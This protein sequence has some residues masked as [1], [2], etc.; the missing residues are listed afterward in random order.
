MAE[1]A[2]AEKGALTRACSRLCRLAVL[3]KRVAEEEKRLKGQVKS[4]FLTHKLDRYE[5]DNGEV[6][7]AKKQKRT[8]DLEKLR[9]ILDAGDFA[10]CTKLVINAK[11]FD[12]LHEHHRYRGL[13]RAIKE[14][15]QLAVGVFPAPKE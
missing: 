1:L 10:K 3:K 15:L 14:Q 4:A 11:V 6:V 8:F 5:T 13:A 12:E 9:K 2:G 7:L